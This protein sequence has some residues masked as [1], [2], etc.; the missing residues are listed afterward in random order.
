MTN[1]FKRLALQTVG[2]AAI[3]LGFASV[4]G[5]AYE[6]EQLFRTH[7]AK[8]AET[9]QQQD[10][11]I[12]QRLEALEKRYGKKPNIVYIL[13]DD[14]GWG[15]LGSYLGGKVRGTPTPNLDELA[16][17]GMKFLSFYSEPICT[18]TRVALMT[19]RLPIR[20]GLDIVLF[21]GQSR[22]MVAEEYTIGELLSDAGYATAMFGKWHLGEQNQH[23]P[24]N[25]GFDYAYYTLYNGGVWPWAENAR[26]YDE[27]NVTIGEIPY[28][29]DMPKNYEETFGIEIFGVLES[30]KGEIPREIEPLTLENYNDHDD[31]LTDRAIQFIEEKADGDKPFFVYLAPVA[32]QVFA[33]PPEQRNEKFVDTANC[34]ASQLLQH[35]KN[36]RRILDKLDQLDIAENTLVV[37]MSDNGPMYDFF[38][39]AGYTWLRGKKGDAYEGGVRVPAIA[40]WPGMIDAGQDPMD[41]VH[42]TDW[43][44]TAARLAGAFDRI[45]NDRVTDG[46]DQSSLLFYGEGASH[47]NYIY[48]YERGSD[49]SKQR[50]GMRLGALR[51]GDIKFH[52]GKGEIYNIIRDPAE[53]FNRFDAYLW[54]MVPFRQ[55]TLL[56]YDLMKRFPN[57]VLEQGRTPPKL[58]VQRLQ[59]E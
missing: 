41:L 1:R 48:H 29:L 52:G 46:I 47:R 24:T 39:S 35:D 43:Y 6:P 20:T 30:R 22:G 7:Q 26:Y 53:K 14:I 8:N 34:Q 54:A 3:L 21:P 2:F 38:P 50:T 19:G 56:H 10:R 44:V 37:W 59:P 55:M 57:R 4:P 36:V 40:Y 12:N 13:A 27:D 32:N 16:N 18:P 33:C 51:Y 31:D 25:Q 28:E 58:D 17:Q 11:E 5:Y 23:Q 45:P 15:E 49:P 42:V 9:W